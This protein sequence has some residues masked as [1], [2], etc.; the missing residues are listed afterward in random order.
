MTC[1][2]CRY[3]NHCGYNNTIVTC[4]KFC[5]NQSGIRCEPTKGCSNADGVLIQLN[6]FRC[7]CLYINECNEPSG[8]RARSKCR[9]L[10]NPFW[11][12]IVW[13]ISCRDPFYVIEI[14]CEIYC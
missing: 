12:L 7:G 2:L 3:N 9:A 14:K 13:L 1:S 5:N 4:L 10:F 11:G 6:P 8:L